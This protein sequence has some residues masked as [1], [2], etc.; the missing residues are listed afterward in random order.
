MA[1]YDYIDVGGLYVAKSRGLFHSIRQ[2]VSKLSSLDDFVNPSERHRFAKIKRLVISRLRAKSGEEIVSL[3]CDGDVLVKVHRGY[4]VF[5]FSAGTVTR[6]FLPDVPD[7]LRKEE[8]DLVRKAS[9]LSCA[10][11]MLLV[12]P[13]S[14]H[15]VEGLAH[16]KIAFSVVE[17][18]SWAVSEFFDEYL[19]SCL[20][21]MVSTFGVSRTAISDVVKASDRCV[22]TIRSEQALNK[23]SVRIVSRFLE[24]VA[25]KLQGC[26]EVP[27]L[28]GFSHG[29]LS[30][31]NIVRTDDGVCLIDWEEAADRSVLSDVY[32]FFFSEMYYSRVSV[33]MENEIDAALER[34]VGELNELVAIDH[35]LSIDHLECY[36]WVYYLERI[37]SLCSRQLDDK[38]LDVTIRL[39]G[40]YTHYENRQGKDRF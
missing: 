18:S 3:P 30:L 6:L 15:Y 2:I 28:T 21:E 40:I 39:I 10:P 25:E 33:M 32:N 14:E 17:H 27:L 11:D 1:I 13:D 9:E 5:D 22:T 37:T 12:G 7:S 38:L 16:G 35:S 23:K 31:R 4:R 29:D 26:A 34:F 36:R 8:I 24:K 19:A 20:L